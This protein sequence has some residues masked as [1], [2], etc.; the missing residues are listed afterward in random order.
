MTIKSTFTASVHQV[1]GRSAH[2]RRLIE[3]ASI[4]AH[5]IIP[6]NLTGF[7]YNPRTLD[8]P[9]FDHNAYIVSLDGFERCFTTGPSVTAVWAWL[10][11]A[12]YLLDRQD[13]YLGGW[14]N[15]ETRRFCLDI[16]VPIRG[17]RHAEQVGEANGQSCIYHPASQR[18]VPLRKTKAA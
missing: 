17:W 8:F 16:S 13:V 12:A 11:D 18:Y 9:V 15:P 3:L 14:P 5:E 4:L 2:R 10:T 6:Q 1:R 7:T